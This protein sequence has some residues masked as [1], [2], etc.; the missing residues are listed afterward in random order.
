M[1][2]VHREAFKVEA[3]ELLVELE[4]ALLELDQCPD[5]MELIQRTFRALH[6]IKGSGAMFGFDTV[7]KFTGRR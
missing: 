3:Q 2:N 4:T 1:I 7:S 5:D 6:T